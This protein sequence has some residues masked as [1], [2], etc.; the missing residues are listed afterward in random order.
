MVI[1][2]MIKW[3]KQTLTSNCVCVC[4]LQ[5]GDFIYQ[6]GFKTELFVC[7][8]CKTFYSIHLFFTAAIDTEPGG[9]SNVIFRVNELQPFILSVS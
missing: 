7:M 6:T 8:T 5:W 1:Y 2:F 9:V 3:H 4:M